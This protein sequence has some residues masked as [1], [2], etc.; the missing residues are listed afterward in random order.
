M[1]RELD[2]PNKMRWEKY[3]TIIVIFAGFIFF[4]LR[5]VLSKFI[6]KP[7]ANK[8][9]I[10]KE[11]KKGRTSRYQKFLGSKKSNLREC[12]VFNILSNTHS[13]NIN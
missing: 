6:Y 13:K 10:E 8:L 11:K 5:Y 7:L 1:N 12:M 9:K 4:F 3:D 2:F